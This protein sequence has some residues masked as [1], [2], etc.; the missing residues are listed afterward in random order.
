MGS[1]SKGNGHFL[2]LISIFRLRSLF[3][4]YLKIWPSHLRDMQLL[5]ICDD[6]ERERERSIVVNMMIHLQIKITMK[7]YVD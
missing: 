4:L 3:L 2:G 5:L 7:D 6:Q 1:G